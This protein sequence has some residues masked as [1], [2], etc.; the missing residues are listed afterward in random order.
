MPLE[1][2]L[3]DSP[4]ATTGSL[5]KKRCAHGSVRL[6]GMC[7]LLEKRVFDE[8]LQADCEQNQ[9]AE[10]LEPPAD[11][12]SKNMAQCRADKRQEEGR[13]ADDDDRIQDGGGQERKADPD[14][15]GVNTGGD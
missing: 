14:R 9:P 13:Q 8:D 11:H 2:T 6:G 12:L 10:E 1:V 4:E 15:Q 7:E 3:A 5:R